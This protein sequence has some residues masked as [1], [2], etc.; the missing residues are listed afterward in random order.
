MRALNAIPRDL[1][2][3]LH[4]IR[5]LEINL[6]G[7]SGTGTENQEVRLGQAALLEELVTAW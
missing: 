1:D 6:E 5:S 3:P 2:F 7:S 4:V